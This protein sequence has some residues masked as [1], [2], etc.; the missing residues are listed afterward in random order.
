[1]NNLFI[2]W[3]YTISNTG[4]ISSSLFIVTT[5][6]LI[7]LLK[8]VLVSVREPQERGAEHYATVFLILVLIF[9]TA[10][11]AFEQGRDLQFIVQPMFIVTFGMTLLLGSND[12]KSWRKLLPISFMVLVSMACTI[13]HCIVGRGKDKSLWNEVGR[14]VHQAGDMSQAI[15]VGNSFASL[16]A[17]AGFLSHRPE[18]IDIPSHWQWDRSRTQEEHGKVLMDTIDKRMS[19]NDILIVVDLMRVDEEILGKRYA[20]HDFTDMVRNIRDHINS[21]YT[22]VDTTMW[23]GFEVTFMKATSKDGENLNQQ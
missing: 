1:M 19:S 5:S 6:L 14:I 21:R 2:L 11:H 8:R 16:D 3:G 12:L 10:M 20:G 22:V 9:G 7:P 13:S 18:M 23:R 15:V 4:W 17:L